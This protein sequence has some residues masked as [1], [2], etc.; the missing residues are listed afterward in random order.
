MAHKI[1]I[2]GII[3]WDVEAKDIKAEFKKIPP[4]A[5]VDV[6]VNSPGGSVFEGIEISNAIKSHKGKTTTIATALT[7]SMGSH[8]MMAGD[9]KKAFNDAT[10]M[11]HNASSIEIGDHRAM[12]KTAGILESLTNILSKAYVNQTGKEISEIHDMMDAETWLFG[13]EIKDAGFVDEIIQSESL[14]EKEEAV[15]YQKLVF[16]DSIEK[17]KEDNKNT[18]EIDKLAALFKEDIK[19]EIPEIKP[20]PKIKEENM[21]LSDYLASNPEAKTEY[22]TVIAEAK[23]EGREELKTE[24]KATSERVLPVVKSGEY[25]ERVTEAGF[26]AMSGERS[27]TSFLDFVSLSDQ[28]NQK[29]KSDSIKIDQPDTTPGEGNTDKETMAKGQTKANAEALSAEINNT[30]KVT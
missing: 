25:V 27:L 29:E 14:T 2:S 8:I 16:M 18:G 20:Q 17:M 15:A 19:N 22:D 21:N 3:G 24:L 4:N 11:I 5:A 1:I 10:F 28:I 23:T 7:A 9:T 30:N 26:E 6:E 13:D 12:R